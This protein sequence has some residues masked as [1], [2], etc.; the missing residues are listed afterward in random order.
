MCSTVV[1][2]IAVADEV[3]SEVLC[4]S[5][6]VDLEVPVVYTEVCNV[7]PLSIVGDSDV[8]VD[9]GDVAVVYV[10]ATSVPDEVNS[11]V[12]LP[13]VEVDGEDGE[14]P[15][16]YTVVCNVDPLSIV[17]MWMWAFGM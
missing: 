4:P 7:D 14:V 17:V 8:E 10:E 12:L 6:E 9:I 15:V 16:V 11:D 1:E 2:N 13:S 3:N 5:V